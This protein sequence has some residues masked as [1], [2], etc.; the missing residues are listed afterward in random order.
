MLWSKD[1]ILAWNYCDKQ[2][3]I[4]AM[5]WKYYIAY[6]PIDKLE[7]RDLSTMINGAFIINMTVLVND[8]TFQIITEDGKRLF[9]LFVVKILNRLKKN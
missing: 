6:P 5:G 1:S 4:E 8:Y 7:H 2:P 9:L 3:V